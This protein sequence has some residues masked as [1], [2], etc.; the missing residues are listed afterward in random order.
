MKL[1][2]TFF[3]INFLL[4]A[5]NNKNSGQV[6]LLVDPE[7]EK[8]IAEFIQYDKK[9]K[10]KTDLKIQFLELSTIDIK[11]KDSTAILQQQ[12]GQE[13]QKKIESA[14]YTVAHYKDAVN[15]Q[16]EKGDDL[17]SKALMGGFL[18]KL[19]HAEEE[20]QKASNWKPDYLNKYQNQDKELLLAKKA[21]C[22]FSMFNPRLQVRQEVDAEFLISKEG[23]KCLGII[24]GGRVIRR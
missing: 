18:D 13:K 2:F 19:E 11:V 5:C 21:V 22:K 9:R 3:I 24:E 6:E 7:Y 15:E 17:V 8:I 14:Q 20:L 16:R 1:F 10:V 23:N 4:I 12:Y